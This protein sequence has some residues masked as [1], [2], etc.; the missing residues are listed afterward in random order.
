M[1]ALLEPYAKFIFS[2]FFLAD[3]HFSKKPGLIKHVLLCEWGLKINHKFVIHYQRI[4]LSNNSGKFRPY[5]SLAVN[6]RRAYQQAVSLRLFS[7]SRCHIYLMKPD[8]N[9]ENSTR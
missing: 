6:R 1:E 7:A 2:F 9:E 3:F 8:I 5:I 4:E